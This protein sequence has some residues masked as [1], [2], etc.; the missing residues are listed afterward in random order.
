MIKI[1]CSCGKQFNVPEEFR[2]RQGRCPGC[3]TVI[4]VPNAVEEIPTFD[5]FPESRRSFNTQELFEQV[6]ES[7][8]GIAHEGKIYGSGVILD[9]KG[10]LA[11]NQHVVGISKKVSVVLNDGAECMGEML[12]AYRDIDLAFVQLLTQPKKCVTVADTDELKVGQ[13]VYAVGHPMG[14]QNTITQGIISAISRPIKGTEYIQTDASI[15][16]GNSG[17]PLFNEYAEVIGINTMILNNAQGLGFAIPID[18]V[19]ERYDTIQK[20]LSS[21]LDKEYCGICGNNSSTFK[22]CENCGVELNSNRRPVRKLRRLSTTTNMYA[23]VKAAKCKICKAYVP[24]H[25][26]YCIK[27]GTQM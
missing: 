24:V 3:G 23:N 6:I 16:P 25:E 27:C 9:E 11:T 5:Q 10:I 14:L 21:I 12:R 18:V 22:Y 7:V 26:K 8:V 2:G 4:V 17:G 20:N 15:N 1:Q 13:S 19:A